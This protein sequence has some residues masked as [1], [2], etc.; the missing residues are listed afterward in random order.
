MASQFH[1]NHR[2]L[3]YNSQKASRRQHFI[4]LEMGWYFEFSLCS[5]SQITT[6]Q[7]INNLH[8]PIKIFKNYNSPIIITLRVTNYCMLLHISITCFKTFSY[9]Y[10]HSCSQ[11]ETSLV[12]KREISDTK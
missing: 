7:S 9:K 5:N 3:S 12:C 6:F 10:W 8:W 4:H 2:D 1:E 11:E